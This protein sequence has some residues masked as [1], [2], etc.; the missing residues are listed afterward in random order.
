VEVRLEPED[1]FGDYDASL[2]RIAER[3]RFPEALELGMRFEGV[4]GEGADATIYRVTD[5]AGGQVVLDGNHP[6]AG[7]AIKF[8]CKVGAI[9][10]ATAEEI[11]RGGIEGPDALQLQ[12]R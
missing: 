2:L 12:L 11:A 1:A 10:Q 4:P 5:I 3:A 8:A 7:M 9:R 6:Y